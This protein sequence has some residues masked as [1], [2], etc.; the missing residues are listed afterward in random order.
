MFKNPKVSLR[1]FYVELKYR[2]PGEVTEEDNEVLIE[3]LEVNVPRLKDSA[4]EKQWVYNMCWNSLT[5]EWQ[6]RGINQVF[7]FTAEFGEM[8]LRL[9]LDPFQDQ[10]CVVVNNPDEDKHEMWADSV[11]QQFKKIYGITLEH[12][13]KLNAKTD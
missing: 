8:L 5:D 10:E 3:T 11:R 4:M 6:H 7:I 2:P 13:E 1:K 9:E 12:W